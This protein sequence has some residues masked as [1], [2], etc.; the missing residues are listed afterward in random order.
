MID[1]SLWKGKKNI[2]QVNLYFYGDINLALDK[3]IKFLP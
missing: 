3:R 2:L 1:G